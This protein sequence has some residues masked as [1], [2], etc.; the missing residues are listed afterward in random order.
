M[1]MDNVCWKSYY[2]WWSIK[3][4]QV[5]VIVL[6]VASDILIHNQKPI[7]LKES[8]I[9]LISKKADLSMPNNLWELPRSTTEWSKTESIWKMTYTCDQT[10]MV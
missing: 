2:F 6:P 8:G 10:K 4:C 5:N 7:L 9:I 3:V 1:R